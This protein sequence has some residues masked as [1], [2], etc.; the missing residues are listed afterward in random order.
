MTVAPQ[1]V[2][3]PSS[4]YPLG[5]GSTPLTFNPAAKIA[6]VNSGFGSTNVNSPSSFQALSGVGPTDDVTQGN[7]LYIRTR[8]L[9]QV[10][11][12]FNNPLGGTTTAINQINGMCVME[13]DPT[14]YLVG[15]S[16]QGVGAVEWLVTGN[17]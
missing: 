9:M 15:I 14:A 6:N 13:I 11:L 7:L 12:T 8:S 10:K 5:T 16:V 1:S 4:T 17:Q 2:S 3:D